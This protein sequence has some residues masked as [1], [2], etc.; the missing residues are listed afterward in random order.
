MRAICSETYRT[1]DR[2][3]TLRVSDVCV[4]PPA[5]PISDTAAEDRR[6]VGP[7][8][9]WPRNERSGW[10]S[11]SLWYPESKQARQASRSWRLMASFNRAIMGGAPKAWVVIDLC[12]FAGHL[13]VLSLLGSIVLVADPINMMQSVKDSAAMYRGSR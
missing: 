10:R 4:W 5:W 8:L 12:S 11:C 1:T 3:D 2:I 6:P 13:T 7:D 9:S